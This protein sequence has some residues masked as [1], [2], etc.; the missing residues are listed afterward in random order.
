[1][2]DHEKYWYVEIALP[3]DNQA[4]QRMVEHAE[5]SAI[6][7]RVLIKSASILA[8]TDEADEERKP[9]SKKKV[10]RKLKKKHEAKVSGVVVTDAAR[11]AAS[12]LLDD[13]GFE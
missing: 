7:L 13:M 8:Y 4:A 1:M 3:K 11:D 12:S 6:P 9:A 10:D 5:K 2:K